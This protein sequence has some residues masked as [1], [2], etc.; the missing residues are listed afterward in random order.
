MKV[1]Q[2][3]D[4][5]MTRMDWLLAAPML[6]LA[7]S[8][9][10]LLVADA[11]RPNRVNNAGICL[12]GLAGAIVGCL[13]L[14][15]EAAVGAAYGFSG[16]VHADLPGLVLAVVC[17][18]SCFLAGLLSWK[19]L[20]RYEQGRHSTALWTLLLVIPLGMCAVIQAVRGLRPGDI[21]LAIVLGHLTRATLS[22]LRFRQ[23]HWRHIEVEIGE[24]PA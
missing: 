20:D 3:W 12:I 13:P 23:G 15:P 24:A 18:G 21:W 11:V 22:V 7:A 19:G 1:F 6:W 14:F 5:V 2:D 17:L 8:A 4:V 9:V 10:L 16:L